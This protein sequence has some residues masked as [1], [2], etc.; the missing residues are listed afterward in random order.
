MSAPGVDA[1]R[2]QPLSLRGCFA[3]EPRVFSDARGRFVKTFQASAFRAAGI[4][5]PFDEDF[6]SASRRDVVRGLH[7][8]QARRPQPKLVYCVRGAA[9]DAVVDL[10]VGSPTYGR[11]ETL[12]LSAER[13]NMVFIG[14][15]FAHGFCALED[16]TV[17]CYKVGS[18]YSPDDDT[19][20]R[21]DTAGIPW[22]TATPIV[23][24]RDRALPPMADFVSTFRHDG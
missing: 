12:E 17:L 21:W 18:E 14:A 15:G 20:V 16:D 11:F 9:F 19:G 1:M 22:P 23:S 7:L 4:E 6:Y 24:D 2:V 10:R 13:A 5:G 3:L 8:Q